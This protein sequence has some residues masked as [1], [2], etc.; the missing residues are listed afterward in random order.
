MRSVHADTSK[1]LFRCWYASHV[2]NTAIVQSAVVRKRERTVHYKQRDKPHQLHRNLLVTAQLLC[3]SH[4]R[5]AGTE[6]LYYIVCHM[7]LRQHGVKKANLHSTLYINSLSLKRSD[8]AACNKEI[9]HFYLPPTHEP[10]LPLFPSRKA[11]SP[12]RMAIAELTWVA[13]H[14]PR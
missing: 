4:Q 6:R 5:C 12:L 11:S 10:Y 7:P 13:G 2:L 3:S 8:M 14:I 9:T 1:R